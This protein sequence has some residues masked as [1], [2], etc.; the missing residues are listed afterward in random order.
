M[1]EL[2][3]NHWRQN[4]SGTWFSSYC[5]CPDRNNLTKLPYISLGTFS[6]ENGNANDDGSKKLHFL[7]TL[8]F[9]LQVNNVWFFDLNF[10]NRKTIKCF[11]M[12][13]NKYW[14]SFAYYVLVV[15]TTLKK[16]SSRSN[17]SNNSE[18]V[19]SSMHSNVQLL[20]L[21]LFFA[22]SVGVA[23]LNVKGHY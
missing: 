14:E 6:N 21:L 20:C 11:S 23:V 8:Y 12:K 15:L 17:F 18:Q 22:V 7:F 16:V 3:V 2:S 13:L 1:R 9:F 10:V 4:I 19:L 5:K